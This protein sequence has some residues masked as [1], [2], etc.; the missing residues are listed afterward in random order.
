MRRALV[1][2]LLLSFFL[3]GAPSDAAPPTIEKLLGE[4]GNQKSAGHWTEALKAYDAARQ[5]ASEAHDQKSEAAALLGMADSELQRGNYNRTASLAAESLAISEMTGNRSAQADALKLIGNVQFEKGDVLASR[6]SMERVLAIRQELGDR[7]GIAIALNNL[8]T[9]YK[10]FDPLTTIDYYNRSQREF[11]ALGDTKRIVVLNNIAAEYGDLGDFSRALEYGKQALALA[12][13]N[14]PARVGPILNV[15]GVNETYFGD[16]KGAISAFDRALAG[17]RHSGFSWGQAEVLNNIGL[18]YQAQRNHPQAIAFFVR[19]LEMDRKLEDHS[20]EAEGRHNLGQE[21]FELGRYSEAAG[22][23]RQSLALSRRY[24]NPGLVADSLTGLARVHARL[25]RLAQASAELTEAIDAER[26]SADKRR[27]ADSLAQF[28]FVKLTLERPQEALVLARES[29][30]SASSTSNQDALW[31]AHLA[32]GRALRKLNREAEATAAFDASIAA[33]EAQRSFIA[34][35]PSSLPLYFADKLEPYQE[36]VALS[37]ARRNVNEALEF[38]EQSKSRTLYDLLASGRTQLDKALSP[39]ERRQERSIENQISSLNAQLSKQPDDAVARARREQ[40]RREL[41]AMETT[42]YATH[43]ELALQRGGPP[44]LSAQDMA[45]VVA[46]THAAVLDYFVTPSRTFLFVVKYGS[47]PQVFTLP[48]A[49]RELARGVTEFRRQLASHD[50]SYAASARDLYRQLV[51]PAEA[52]LRGIKGI[53]IVPDGQLWNVPFHAL[54][55]RPDHFLIED[56]SVSYAPSIAVL[57]ETLRIARARMASPA[58]REL[59]ALGNS[60][61]DD[62]LPEAERQVRE[63]QKLYGAERSL[64]LTGEAASEDR[65]KVEAPSYRVLHLASHAV[66]DDL[67]PMYSQVRLAK[68][69][70]DGMLEARELAAFDLKAELLV[71]SACE[72]ASGPAPPGEGIS[73]M[74]WAAFAAGAPTTVASL[75]RVESVSTSQMM[76]EFHRQWLANRGGRTLLAKSAALR[77]AALQLVAS[78]RYSHPFYWAGFILAGNPN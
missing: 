69:R 6:V 22:Q 9:T 10:T 33:I 57:R 73:G 24:S 23:F 28:A 21:Y 46:Q 38:V 78:G 76:I 42:L 1:T 11:E 17:Y 14:D 32:A 48:I 37:V 34:G 68:G 77:A 8:G 62:P 44:A 47:K 40:L 31:Q 29:A 13:K 70:D 25:R 75:W 65:V 30:D 27:L 52:Y 67:N 43:Q 16:Y 26:D 35:P 66:L 54:Q 56:V 7:G 59:L 19:A 5:A 12:E 71:L 63:I 20:L 45:D 72:T 61:G 18:V 36:R 60:G 51:G 58:A 74:L 3:I 49:E 50:L 41:E 55:P 2:G 53:V 39:E 15:L 4:A 64:V